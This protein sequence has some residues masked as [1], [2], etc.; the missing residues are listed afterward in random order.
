MRKALEPLLDL[1]GNYARGK[2]V[3]LVLA[4]LQDENADSRRVIDLLRDKLYHL[5]AQLAEAKARIKEL[6][7]EERRLIFQRIHTDGD[8]KPDVREVDLVEKMDAL[9]ERLIIRE[10]ETI[11]ALAEAEGCRERLSLAQA[12]ITN[13]DAKIEEL[14]VFKDTKVI[15]EL[16]IRDF[17]DKVGVLEDALATSN[18]EVSRTREEVAGLQVRLAEMEASSDTMRRELEGAKQ[19]AENAKVLQDALKTSNTELA[20]AQ[21]GLRVQLAEKQ[22][23]LEGLEHALETMKQESTKAYQAAE[24]QRALLQQNVDAQSRELKMAKEAYGDMQKESK[25]QTKLLQAADLR[26]AAL[27]ERFDARGVLLERAQR[28]CMELK[29]ANQLF[30]AELE[31]TKCALDATRKELMSEKTASIASALDFASKLAANEEHVRERVDAVGQEAQTAHRMSRLLEVLEQRLARLETGHAEEQGEKAALVERV[32]ELSGELD[33]L[34][35]LNQDILKRTSG[36]KKR[37]E[38]NEL[39]DEEKLFVEW[40]MQLSTSLHEQDAVAKDNE[41][42]RRE[43]MN[44]KLQGKVRELESTLAR[45]LK[46]KEKDAGVASKSIIDLNAWMSSSPDPQNASINPVDVVMEPPPDNLTSLAPAPAPIDSKKPLSTNAL[47][48]PKSLPTSGAVPVAMVSIPNVQPTILRPVGIPTVNNLQSFRE[49]DGLSSIEDSGSEEEIPLSEMSASATVLGKREREPSPAKPRTA[50]T[51]SKIQNTGAPS[52]RRL[53]APIAIV[54]AP[55]KAPA[56]AIQKKVQKGT[57]S[58]AA[59]PKRKK[60]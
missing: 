58:N 5:P 29:E 48:T 56:V 45:M 51:S 28:Q 59:K 52:A 4:E 55:P 25:E 42:R 47:A 15:L 3:K 17:V 46:E 18:A 16:R 36:L 35:R 24:L 27:Q 23:S 57:D 19:E 14:R 21:K 26:A 11:G 44:L 34:E 60:K 1:D 32:K 10:Q 9:I 33:R 22:K 49:L 30:E 31:S 2:Q 43:T 13:K 38:A 41:L 54:A 7:A 8:V 50:G 6:E 39:N 20:H 53:K 40:L 12:E 37:Y